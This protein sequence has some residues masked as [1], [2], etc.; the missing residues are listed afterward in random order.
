MK[1][2]HGVILAGG[3]SKR[4]GSDKALALY[5]G[6]PLIAHAVDLIGSVGLEAS[7]VTE[8]SRDYSLLK[9][10]IF[11]DRQSFQGPLA[12][13]KRAFEVFPDEK[14]LVLTCD[15]LFLTQEDLRYLIDKNLEEAT[16]VL[17]RL[18]PE[19]FQPFPGIYST[20]LENTIHLNDGNRNSMQDFLKATDGILEISAK[21]FTRNFSNINAK[22]SISQD[23]V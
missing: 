12:G 1:L 4:F 2:R 14:I 10:P 6:K 19:R 17:Y 23:R 5:E 9:C 11:F 3:Q 22:K 15:M 16:I 18:H 20:S 21:G 7:V 13:L 8:K